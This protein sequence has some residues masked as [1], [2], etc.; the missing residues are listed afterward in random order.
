MTS[1][2]YVIRAISTI[3][4]VL[5]ALSPAPDFWNIYKTKSTGASSI[6]PVDMIFCNCYVWVLYAYLVNNILPLF[7]NCCLEMFTSLVFGAIYFRWSTSRPHVH[8]VCAIAFP[9]LVAHT[10]YYIVGTSG[11]TNQSDDAV[12]K[13]LGVLSDNFSIFLFASPLEAMKQVIQTKD[14]TSLPIIIS[15]IFL[16]NT[17]II[18]CRRYVNSSAEHH[19]SA[20]HEGRTH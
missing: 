11:V 10:I 6:L 3:T 17:T 5:V 13:V 4:A 1:F 18:R 12:E 7:V 8:K 9:G 14:A 20:A 16:T 15:A 19:V 2:L